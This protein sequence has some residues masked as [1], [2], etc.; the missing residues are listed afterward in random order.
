METRPSAKAGGWLVLLT[1]PILLGACGWVDSTGNGGND[2]DSAE[3]Q[4]SPFTSAPAESNDAT[5]EGAS[6]VD[7]EATRIVQLID[8]SRIRVTPA[9]AVDD[10]VDWTWTPEATRPTAANCG[11]SADF[12]NSIAATTLAAACSS[13]EACELQIE[14]ATN[15]SG[16]TVFDFAVPALQAPVGLGYR[17]SAFAADGTVYNEFYSFCAISINEAPVAGNDEFTVVRGETR[18]VL[19]NDTITLLSNDS[20]DLDVRNQPLR[21]NT[22][23]VVAPRL[24]SNF[25]LLEDGGFVYSAPVNGAAGTL[26]D[27]FQYELS[28][29]LHTSTATVTIRIVDSN[30]APLVTASV[31]DLRFVVGQSLDNDPGLDLSQ[32]FQD[33]DSNSLFFTTQPGSLPASG[34]IQ[35]TEAGRI[36]GQ[37]GAEDIG[38][39]RVTLIASDG[40]AATSDTFTLSIVSDP[41]TDSNSTP[42]ID[43]IDT[44]IVEQGDR[45]N[46][47][48]IATDSD[49]DDLVYS[50][51]NQTADF[52]SIGQNNGRIRGN[53]TEA[54]I[55]P[56]TVIVSD[57]SSSTER[58]FVLRVISEE[59][60]P[61]FVDDI[62][63]QTVEG[64]FA[65]DVSVFFTDPEGDQMTFTATN[66]PEGVT[67]SSSG[68]ISGTATAAN[69]GRHIIRVTADD[70]NLGMADD[71]FRLTISL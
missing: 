44:L 30:R 50:L 14:T 64:A 52:L 46:L 58:M 1:L 49:G 10:I 32:F 43:P 4:F 26:F 48:V 35:I 25:N 11:R 66:L 33:P 27:S 9:L 69:A 24:A 41:T 19:A 59:N 31:P 57:S 20:D 63:N 17:L 2:S 3:N 16:G 40:S 45:I 8:Q 29:G 15:S 42:A 61:P 70:G 51:S 68:T 18:I 38:D 67:I 56:V 62:S 23:P 28:D 37:A 34:N 22:Q 6:I 71:G 7:L 65:Y 5:P 55:F 13:S 39:Y 53:A 60:R 36:T 54:G 21:I 47:Q 12:D